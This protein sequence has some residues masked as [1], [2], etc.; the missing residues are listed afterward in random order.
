MPSTRITL[1]AFVL[2]AGC[3]GKGPTDSADST[4]GD[5]VP[6][7]TSDSSPG[8]GFEATYA[9]FDECTGCHSGEAPQGD[10]DLST[11]AA[12]YAALV[13][14][15]AS[16]SACGDPPHTRVVPGDVAGSLLYA[17]LAMTQDCGFGMPSGE[18][19]RVPPPFTT[20]QLATVAAWIS[21]GAVE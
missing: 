17:K 3:T 7:D 1:L 14:Q 13:G 10:L 21:G 20:D 2:L 15:P 19:P 12:A 8:P 16:G 5:S 9:L 4:S 18:P 6:T 11:R